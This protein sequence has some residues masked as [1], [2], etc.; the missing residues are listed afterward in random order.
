MCIY[1]YIYMHIYIY[2]YV[3]KSYIYIYTYIVHICDIHAYDIHRPPAWSQAPCPGRW[4]PAA[5]PQAVCCCVLLVLCVHVCLL[6]LLYEHYHK[7]GIIVVF[8][9]GWASITK[10][11]RFRSKPKRDRT[12]RGVIVPPSKLIVKHMFSPKVLFIRGG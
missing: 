3:Y 8:F 12:I 10:G 6:L 5:V 4:G 2:I 7:L 1:I 11:G 9:L